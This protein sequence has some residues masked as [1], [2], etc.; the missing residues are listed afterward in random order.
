MEYKDKCDKIVNLT[1]SLKELVDRQFSSGIIEMD[2][3]SKAMALTN[4]IQTTLFAI[5]HET[6]QKISKHV[7][8]ITQENERLKQTKER[9]LNIIESLEVKPA[10]KTEKEEPVIEHIVQEEKIE[11]LKVDE[12]EAERKAEI[13]T[14]TTTEHTTR[15][16]N[17]IIE[18]KAL[19]DI[20][21]SLSLN[22]RFRYRRE[23]F[24]GSDEQMNSALE[25]LNAFTSAD[26]SISYI[27]NTLGWNTEDE[28]AAEFIKLIEKRFS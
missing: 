8:E 5:D 3:T 2:F 10:D 12:P 15:P 28:A 26:E 9:L 14:E 19:A 16:L 20:R 1:E 23:L 6:N 21:R 24:G 7:I 11:P 4:E 18:K 25:R 27:K 17:E 22:D 13:V